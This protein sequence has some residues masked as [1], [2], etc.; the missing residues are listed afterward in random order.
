MREADS[1]WRGGLRESFMEEAEFDLGLAG[2]G[3]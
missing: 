2:L 3:H 1:S